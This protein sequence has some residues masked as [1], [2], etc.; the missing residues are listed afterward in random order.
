[1]QII[2]TTFEGR[3][4]CINLL[5]KCLPWRAASTQRHLSST[6]ETSFRVLTHL[7]NLAPG[8][9]SPGILCWNCNFRYDKSIYA[10]FDTNGCIAYKLIRVTNEWMVNINDNCRIFHIFWQRTMTE[11]TYKIL[12][13]DWKTPGFFFFQKNGNPV[14]CLEGICD[15]SCSQLTSTGTMSA[16][17]VRCHYLGTQ[18]SC[19][20]LVN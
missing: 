7:E 12:K 3:Q 20:C 14:F 15:A 6:V 10:G 16:S 4:Q 18:F 9:L 5:L 13:L 1:M 17:V 2:V 8:N 11:S 19:H